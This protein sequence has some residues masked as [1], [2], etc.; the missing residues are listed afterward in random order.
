[1]IAEAFGPEVG[2]ARSEE[3]SDGFFNAAFRLL[4][5][6]G[7]DVVLKASPPPEAALLTY[8][9][10]I[11]RAEV[12]YF[13]AAAAADGV[14]L[15]EL[16]HA[17]LDR[18]IIDG[19]YVVLSAVPGV[20]WNSVRETLAEP[21]AA[22]LRRELGGHLAR[23]HRIGNPRRT[24]GYP[25]VPELSAPTWP[26]AFAAM[27]GALV[28]DA[29]RYGVTLP[30]SGEDLRAAV[31]RNADA[32][33]AIT[34]PA[35]VHFDLW[36]GNI[37]ISVPETAAPPRINGLIDGER[38]IWGDPLMEFVGADVFGRADRD[39]DIRAGYL[40]A[41]GTIADDAP[42][43]RRL[44]LYHLY[45]QLLLLVETAPRGYTDQAYLTFV[46]SECPKRILA[47]VQELG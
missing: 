6:D 2:V 11:M 31:R 36:P 33:A 7:R 26:D 1:M 25:A 21:Q 46:A 12:E 27:L 3:L 22:A 32:L 39:P 17:G 29:D 19:D 18:T 28:D 10:D 44:V 38:V 15:P 41:G 34:A 5:T 24:F 47:A 9:R 30:V 37:L 4:L 45:M 20:T 23:L 14:P 35:L 13:N 43:Q 16:V 40:G 8:E 42:A